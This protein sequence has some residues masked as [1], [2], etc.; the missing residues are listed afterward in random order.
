MPPSVV[1]PEMDALP[2]VEAVVSSKGQVTLPA[3]MRAKLGIGPGS[4][5]HFELRGQE[6]VIKPELPMSAYRGILKGF[7]LGNIEP[8]REPDRTFE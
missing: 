3:A 2:T 1:S 6:L 8:E 7:D 5:I 4:H